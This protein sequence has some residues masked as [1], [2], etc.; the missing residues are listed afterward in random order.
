MKY[1]LEKHNNNT[2]PRDTLWAS[3]Y[4]NKVITLRRKEI[5]ASKE[6]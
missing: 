6:E 3:Y 5:I 2:M 1:I 4:A